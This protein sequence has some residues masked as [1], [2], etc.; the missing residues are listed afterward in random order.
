VKFKVIFILFNVLIVFSFA[1]ILILPMTVFGSEYASQFWKDKWFI[2]I[3]FVAVLGGLNVFFALNWKLFS[4][5][6]NE[7][8]QGLIGYLEEQIMVKKKISKRRVNLLINTYLL[9]SGVN[10]LQ[11]LSL[12]LD[13]EKPEAKNHF[14][15]QFGI[16]ALIENDPEGISEYFGK[17]LHIKSA[18]GEWVNWCYA[19]G[20]IMQK[21]VEDGKINLLALLEGSSKPLVRLLS[22]YLLDSIVFENDKYREQITKEKDGFSRKYTR[23]ILARE[24]EKSKNNILIVVLLKIINQA[25]DWLFPPQE[26]KDA[27]IS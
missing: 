18:D 20:L 17:Y 16:P 27:Q 13:D 21:K 11:K 2:G 19:F 14:I 8:W 7:N 6:E 23:G 1:M 12:F 24:L 25:I 3:F 10:N 26:A 4:Y 5:L 22:L 9:H 15:I